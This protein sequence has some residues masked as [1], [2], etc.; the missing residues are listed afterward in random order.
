M[1]VHVFICNC[2]LYV[3]LRVCICLYGTITVQASVRDALST[4]CV[5][6]IQFDPP[7]WQKA[8]LITEPS[9]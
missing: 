3:C 1:C 6:G 5:S 9:P 4:M 8:P 7:A 2:L